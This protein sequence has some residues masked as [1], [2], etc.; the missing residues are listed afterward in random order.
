MHPQVVIGP[1]G[2]AHQFVPLLVLVLALWEEPVQNIDGSNGIVG[3]LLF[4]LFVERHVAGQDAEAPEP[5]LKAVDPLLMD[6]FR[7]L[8][9]AEILHLHLLKFAGAE[10]K[11]SR[12]YLI[13]KRLADLRDTEWQLSA[14]GI[15][16]IGKVDEDA[17]R[18]FGSKVG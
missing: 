5:R 9:P 8:L 4:G 16:H 1:V 11:V 17:L 14:R 6:V 2:D 7:V 3:K 18:S 15:K 10:D 13:T 12:R